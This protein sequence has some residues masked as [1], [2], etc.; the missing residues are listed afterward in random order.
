M[1]PKNM[2]NLEDILISVATNEGITADEERLVD[3]ITFQKTGKRFGRFKDKKKS[4]LP[5]DIPILSRDGVTT[6]VKGKEGKFA[7][8]PTGKTERRAVTQSQIS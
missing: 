3:L 7:K 1:K 5:T 8:A 4:T 2:R 6:P